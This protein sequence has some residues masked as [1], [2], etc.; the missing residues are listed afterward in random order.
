MPG[1]VQVGNFSLITEDN[2]QVYLCGIMQNKGMGREWANIGWFF[3]FPLL[4]IKGEDG[5]IEAGR[6]QIM[7]TVNDVALDV[8]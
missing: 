1:K 7:H 5:K 6:Y 3:L 2:Q 4:F 8:K